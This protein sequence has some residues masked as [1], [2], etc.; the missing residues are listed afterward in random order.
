MQQKMTLHACYPDKD[1]IRLILNLVDCQAR[2]TAPPLLFITI[3]NSPIKAPPPLLTP[4][5][6]GSW[7]LL[8]ISQPKIVRFSFCKKLL[9]GENVLS[10]MIAPPKVWLRTAPSTFIGEVTV[11]GNYYF[12]GEKPFQCTVC[13]LKMQKGGD[14]KVHMYKH[15]GQLLLLNGQRYAKRSLMS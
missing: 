10:P 8:A 5:L 2:L 7:T 14:L 6:L 9:E 4:G 15:T 12:S 3:V 11:S 1:I 13:G